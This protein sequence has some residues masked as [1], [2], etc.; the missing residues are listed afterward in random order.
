MRFV[1]YIL[2]NKLKTSRHSQLY[3]HHIVRKILKEVDCVAKQPTTQ[4]QRERTIITI[5]I[6]ITDT[7]STSLFKYID[8]INGLLYV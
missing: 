6:I 4:K 1:E 8:N 7:S 2:I 3:I 5:N